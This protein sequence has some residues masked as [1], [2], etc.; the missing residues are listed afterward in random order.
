MGFKPDALA[1]AAIVQALDKTPRSRSELLKR[2][3][4]DDAHWRSVIDALVGLGV[5]IRTGRK[6]GTKYTCSVDPVAPPSGDREPS[7]DGYGPTEVPS[8]RTTSMQTAAPSAFKARYHDVFDELLAD[9]LL[10]NKE[11]GASVT[12]VASGAK[13]IVD[14]LATAGLEFVDH[15]MSGGRLWVIDGP[16]TATTVSRF[17]A[18]FN[19]RFRRATSSRACGGRPAWWTRDDG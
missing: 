4:A 12:E 13:C 15:R 5:A 1:F 6:R 19:V 17:A 10:C 18:T 3:D 11:D 9:I 14:A 2:A 8:R 16:T 7:A